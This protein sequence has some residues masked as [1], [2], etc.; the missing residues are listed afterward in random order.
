M[1]KRRG[2][3]FWVV[4]TV[5]LTIVGLV[6]ALS[7]YEV[8][9][10]RS[11]ASHP[12]GKTTVKDRVE[13]NVWVG[14]IDTTTQTATLEVMAHPLGALAD[15]YGFFKSDATIFTSALKAD[16]IKI[17]AGQPI[18]AAEVKV[19]VEGTITDYPFDSYDSV[20]AF[21]VFSGETELPVSA[22]ISSGDTFFE[23]T[24]SPVDG[25]VNGIDV[26]LYAE[27]SLPS[28]VFA[29]FIMLLMLGLAVA[30]ATACH[31]V[32]AG[33]RGLMFPAVSMMGALL[34]ALVPLRN[35]VPG[36][37]PIGS[38]IDFTSFFIAEG[39]ISVA[40]VGTVVI[41]YRVESAKERAESAEKQDGQPPKPPQ[42]QPVS[43]TQ[44]QPQSQYQPVPR[45]QQQYPGQQPPPLGQHRPLL[46]Q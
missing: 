11:E 29:M 1:K 2:G 21:D 37:P 36:T 42:P 32:L 8:G 43:H 17:K 3:A 44:F 19:V 18:S 23:V 45:Y 9:R 39:I 35:A 38:L 33:K 25:V 12:F 40:L 5:A 20:L 27:R 22:S 34:F 14:K 41:G 6:L 24:E 26:D 4:T 10:T 7:T 30:A 13:L 28:M 15:K 31:Y 16:P 46:P